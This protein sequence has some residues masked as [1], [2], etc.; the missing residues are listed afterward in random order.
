MA[1]M[2]QKKA[3]Q[4]VMENHGNVSKAMRDAGYSNETAKNPRNLTKSKSWEELLEEYFPDDKLARVGDEGLDATRTI[5]ATVLVKSDN[6]NVK[7]K[8]AN[9]RDV[10]FIDVP[11]YQTRHKYYDTALKL[12]QKYPPEKKDVYIKGEI[13]M[14]W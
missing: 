11:D 10:D 12:K 1:T 5:S 14:Y 8:Q 9:A 4:N 6:P 13:K 3:V 7:T 2:K